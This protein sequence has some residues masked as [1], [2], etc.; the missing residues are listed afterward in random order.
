MTWK[1]SNQIFAETIGASIRGIMNKL[2]NTAVRLP[3][4]WLFRVSAMII[5]RVTSAATAII[6]KTNVHC[7]AR[8]KLAFSSM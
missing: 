7:A 4:A 6:E 8:R 5:P 2:L 1:R 3:N